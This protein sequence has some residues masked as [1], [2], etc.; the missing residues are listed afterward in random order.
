VLFVTGVWIYTRATS[1]RDRVGTWAFVGVT[2]F[3]AIGFAANVKAPPPPSITS[4]WIVA[5][6]LGVLTI[7]LGWWADKHRISKEG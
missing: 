4:L 5:L 1:A 2:A 6:L 3:L 7:A